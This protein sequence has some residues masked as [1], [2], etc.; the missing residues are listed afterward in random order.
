MYH[1]SAIMFFFTLGLNKLLNRKSRLRV[2]WNYLTPARQHTHTLVLF[3]F[4]RSWYSQ[5]LGQLLSFPSPPSFLRPAAWFPPPPAS[6]ATA[7]QA[8]LC[9]P[10]CCSRVPTTVTWP[11]AGARLWVNSLLTPSRK[12]LASPWLTIST[13]TIILFYFILCDAL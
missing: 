10:T 5:H 13:M 8:I 7:A 4:H 2:K 1:L 6:T 3:P 12:L 11:P 9:L